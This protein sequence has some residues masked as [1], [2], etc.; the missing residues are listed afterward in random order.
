MLLALPLLANAQEAQ[1]FRLIDF[2]Q[3]QVHYGFQ[4]GLFTS[5]LNIKHSDYF[6]D[7]AETSDSTVAISPQRQAS[8]SLGFVVNHSLNDELWDLRLLPN[9]SFYT[10]T[11]E[12]DYPNSTESVTIDNYTTFIEL[13]LMLKYAS[14]RRNN[15]RF[16][17]TGGFTLGYGVGGRQ[18]VETSSTNLEFNRWNFEI[19]YGIGLS[20]Y[21]ELFNFAP[22]LRFSHGMLNMLNATESNYSRNLDRVTTHKVALILNFEG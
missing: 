22:E 21:M 3:K 4:I 17:V 5:N 19:S 15:H 10:H 12:F 20:G 16:Y 6:L 2:D 11:L 13:P 1:T 8:F 9:V 18:S 7:E 14:L